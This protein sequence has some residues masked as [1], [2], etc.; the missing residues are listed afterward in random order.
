[1]LSDRT[2]FLLSSCLQETMRI[3]KV[4]KKIRFIFM[5]ILYPYGKDN[6]T[7]TLEDSKVR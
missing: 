2:N 4:I 3:K 7:N 6:E 1:L 5:D